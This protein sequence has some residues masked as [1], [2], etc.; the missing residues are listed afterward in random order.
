MREEKNEEFIWESRSGTG[1]ENCGRVT[2]RHL[3]LVDMNIRTKFIS[4]FCTVH[5][6]P[7][8]SSFLHKQISKEE[9]VKQHSQA[10]ALLQNSPA[11]EV[12]LLRGR[13]K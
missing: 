13:R 12:N 5:R 7:A 4:S 9:N 8:Y 6:R 1:L 3:S 2:G 11:R 10:Y